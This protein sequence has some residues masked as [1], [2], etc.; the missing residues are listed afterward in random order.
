MDKFNELIVAIEGYIDV[1]P[2]THPE[3]ESKWRKFR[4][5][6]RDLSYCF[7]GTCKLNFT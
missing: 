6:E 4:M 3:L 1:G 5:S 2:T 7:H